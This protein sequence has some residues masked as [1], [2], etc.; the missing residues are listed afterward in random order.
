MAYC[1]V[2]HFD[3]KPGNDRAVRLL[4][5]QAR[6]IME[7][8]PGLRSV[9]FFADYANGHG[10]AVS[11]WDSVEDIENYVKS[12]SGIMRVATAGLFIDTPKS[13]IAEVL[14]PE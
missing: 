1:R 10:G 2:F 4:A 13:L 14:E 3:F 6:E 12:S 7:R 5:Q 11:L 9:T 8:Q